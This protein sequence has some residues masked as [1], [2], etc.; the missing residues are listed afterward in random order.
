MVIL[1]IKKYLKVDTEK[2]E[3]LLKNESQYSILKNTGVSQSYLSKIV[4]GSKSIENLTVGLAS[5]LTEYALSLQEK[6]RGNK[7]QKLF[8]HIDETKQSSYRLEQLIKSSMVNDYFCF[9]TYQEL[10]DFIRSYCFREDQ[11]FESNIPFDTRWEQVEFESDP[12]DD[13]AY[14]KFYESLTEK[15]FKEICEEFKKENK[16]EYIEFDVDDEIKY[17]KQ[18]TKDVLAKYSDFEQRAIVLNFL[19]VPY[20]QLESEVI[21]AL[22]SD[23]VEFATIDNKEQFK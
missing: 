20:N 1:E 9:D 15:D 2:I 3:W 8:I 16:I 11:Y 13:D 21:E 23:E 5:K 4:N 12:E 22:E 6:R 14:N 18:E 10:A 7:M 17:F 19:D